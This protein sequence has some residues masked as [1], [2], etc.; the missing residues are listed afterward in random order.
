MKESNE[1]TLLH[2]AHNTAIAAARAGGRVALATCRS[3]LEKHSKGPR[4]I[5]TNGDYAAQE[6]VLHCIRETFPN[7]SI[8]SEEGHLDGNDPTYRWEVSPL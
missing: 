5:V 1:A 7:H 2:V 8:L 3:P 4:D 6:A